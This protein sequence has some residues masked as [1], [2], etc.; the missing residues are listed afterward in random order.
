MRSIARGVGV[1]PALVAHYF[2]SKQGLF[3]ASL[4]L[5]VDIG[6]LVTGLLAAG[7]DGIGE[8][9]V[10]TF[11]AVWDA[12][13][14]QGPMLAMLR[15]AVSH[16]DSATRLREMLAQQVMRPI[17]TATA[18]D[19]VELR[20]S[21]VAAQMVGL[22]MARYVLRFEPLATMPADDLARVIGATV[23]RYLTAELDEAGTPARSRQRPRA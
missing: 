11:L 12:T 16:P 21:L 2:G 13:P 3:E 14:G 9:V 7:P 23:Q 22:A 15:G 19:R 4:E 18:T 6:A 1:D 8:R 20:A 5:P 10:R 17:A